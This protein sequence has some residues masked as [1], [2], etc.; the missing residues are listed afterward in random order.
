MHPGD[1]GCRTRLFCSLSIV[2]LQS[3]LWLWYV[4]TANRQIGNGF[5]K[6][7][8]TENLVGLSCTYNWPWSGCIDFLSYVSQYLPALCNTEWSMQK[9]VTFAIPDQVNGLSLLGI[10][11][12]VTVAGTPNPCDLK[13]RKPASK[14][15]GQVGSWVS[16]RETQ[17]Q[18]NPHTGGPGAA[19]ALEAT[20]AGVPG[21]QKRLML[22]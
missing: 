2:W 9:R 7:T 20:G 8:L 12:L 11:L 3:H 4:H 16:C 13:G 18:I 14:R 1:P 22:K 5:R 17:S 15:Y 21:K 6:P 10:F 19:S